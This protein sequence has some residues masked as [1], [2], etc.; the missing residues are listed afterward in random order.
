M[1]WWKFLIVIVISYLIGNI[2]F[3]RIIS[4]I[5]HFDISKSGSGNP[6]TMNMLRNLGFGIGL[7]TL[8]LDML[9]GVIPALLGFYLFGGSGVNA[10]IG[11]FTGGLS[12]L[13]G[14]LFPVFYKFNGGKGVAVAYGMFCAA[15]PIL[16]IILFFAGIIFL[17]LI[18]YGSLLSFFVI[19]VF[20]IYEAYK[21]GLMTGQ[22]NIVLS[23]LLFLIFFLV[24]FAHRQNIFRL[25]VGKENRVNFRRSLSKIGKKKVTQ[26][27]TKE[28]EIG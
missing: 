11:L 25:L 6:G 13:V 24:W 14:T 2:Y 22:G 21:L 28:K 10:Y 4:R 20:T 8:F 18:D 15:E 17:L 26:V 3:A 23:I 7:L 9:K 12:S 19:T 5:K 16:G 27:E 1:E